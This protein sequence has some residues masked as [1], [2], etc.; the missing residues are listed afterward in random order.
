M[1]NLKSGFTANSE[2]IIIRRI[3]DACGISI[4]PRKINTAIPFEREL[5]KLI[6]FWN[7]RDDG[8]TEEEIQERWK[9]HPWSNDEI[10]AKSQQGPVTKNQI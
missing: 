3:S 1:I 10:Q 5:A 9:M 4:G 6:F 8:L 7:L 2:P